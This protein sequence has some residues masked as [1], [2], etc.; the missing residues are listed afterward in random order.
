MARIFFAM[1]VLALT[2]AA[3]ADDLSAA[4]DACLRHRVVAPRPTS[5]QNVRNS[6]YAPGFEACDALIKKIQEAEQPSRDAADI[7]VINKALGQ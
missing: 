5:P 1:S 4:K 6:R 2:T 7:A 3:L